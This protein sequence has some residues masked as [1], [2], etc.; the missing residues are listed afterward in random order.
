MALNVGYLKAQT[1]KESDE[2]FTPT[3][4][5]KPIIKY[6]KPGSVVW[7]P[8]DMPNSKYVE[9]I[10]KAGFKVIHSHIDEGKDFFTYEPKERYDV[11]ISNPPFSQKDAVLKRLWELN[12]PYAVL[13]PVPV[14]Q[15]QKRFPY[16]KE[17]QYF[18][19][20]KRVNYYKDENMTTI[21]EGVSFGS[22]YICRN[23]LPKDLI[24]EELQ[25]LEKESTK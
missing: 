1:T 9:E 3:Y 23:F 16:L 22:C 20:D 21:Q 12:K 8:F 15:G 4:A 25:T 17:C 18:G 7:C 2:V 5:V 11:I 24:I 19:F 10:E 14:L 13:L 6:I